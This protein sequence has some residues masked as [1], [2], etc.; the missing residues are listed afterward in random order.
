MREMSTTA[1]LVAVAL[2]AMLCAA[3]AVAGCGGDDNGNGQPAGQNG[4]PQTVRVG[5]IPIAPVAPLYLGIDQG[6]FEEEGLRVEPTL[7]QGG[8]AIVPAVVAG[9]QEFGFSN[10]VSLMLAQNRGL[11]VKIVTQGS[12]STTSPDPER[13]FAAV[14][15]AEDSEIREPADLAG[16]TIAVNTLQNIGDLTITAALQEQGVDTDTIEYREIPFPEMN[17]ALL[18]GEVDAVWQEEPFLVQ[19]LNEGARIVLQHYREF[20]DHLTIATYFTTQETIDS[21]PELVESFARAMN[22]SLQYAQENPDEVRRIVG[23]Y[24][25]IPEAAAKE[26]VLPY[27]SQDLNVPSIEKLARVGT[28]QEIFD[29]E[30]NVDELIHRPE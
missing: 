27:F 3:G 5:V 26:M 18:D 12:Q 8:A 30:P 10:V 28:E 23:T 15:V 14:V 20:A 4:E 13:D 11:D 2:V 7:A 9:E 24:T 22:R 6:F 17:A 21:D 19:L 25:E 1:R 16:A 29:E